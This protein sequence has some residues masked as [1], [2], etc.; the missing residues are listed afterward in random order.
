MIEELLG[1]GNNT[2]HPTT[3]TSKPTPQASYY[4]H[5]DFQGA[6]LQFPAKFSH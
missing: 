4:Q 6:N 5:Y 3:M 1:Q 2:N